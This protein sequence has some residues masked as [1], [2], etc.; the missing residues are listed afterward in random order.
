MGAP[1][2]EQIILTG[3][4][5]NM[6]KMQHSKLLVLTSSEISPNFPSFLV[7]IRIG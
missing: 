2:T 4:A 7:L 6:R 3:V 5:L 1:K